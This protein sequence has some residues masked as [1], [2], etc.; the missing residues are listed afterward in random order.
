MIGF[1]DSGYGGLTVL[2]ACQHALPEHD[3]AYLGDNGRA[4]YGG[5][6][7]ENILAYT[8][9]GV[10]FLFAQGCELVILACNTSS[11]VALR[12][13]QQNDL[14]RHDGRK[15]VLGVVVPLAEAVQAQLAAQPLSRRRAAL[16]G[17][18]AT[19]QSQAYE[20]EI[21][22]LDPRITIISQ[23]CPRL[24][25]LIERSPQAKEEMAGWLGYYLKRVVDLAPAVLVP[26]CTHYALIEPEIKKTLPAS[27]AVM[28]GPQ[29]VA[30]KLM[31]YLGRHTRLRGRLPL[32]GQRFF[33]TS[34]EPTAFDRFASQTLGSPV[35]CTQVKNLADFK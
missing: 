34:G 22:K 10:A 8:R 33:F 31:Q 19:V 12:T 7:S 3:Y 30:G 26:A 14:A 21:N 5:L 20:K 6:D 32:T 27:I 25:P 16:I 35:C 11:A 15:K 24:V 29:V 9:Q 4:P 13:I 23:A 28:N 18:A 17:T 2:K 1:F